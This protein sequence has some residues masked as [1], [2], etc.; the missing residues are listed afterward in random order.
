V[1]AKVE[2]APA[3]TTRKKKRKK[4]MKLVT[5]GDIASSLAMKKA[6]S[7][8]RQIRRILL[9]SYKN[10]FKKKMRKTCMKSRSFA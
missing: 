1:I 3:P 7:A 8:N 10:N 2:L 4:K 6:S 5:V 9:N